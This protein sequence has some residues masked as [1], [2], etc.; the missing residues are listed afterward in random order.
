MS[1]ATV[2]RNGLRGRQWEVVMVAGI[3]GYQVL[4][5][6]TAHTRRELVITP[7][8][9]IIRVSDP[10][11]PVALPQDVPQEPVGRPQSDDDPPGAARMH[12]DWTTARRNHLVRRR[13]GRHI[14]G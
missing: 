13:I 12:A 14:G 8:G 2:T 1:D 5:V 6:Q 11:R 7:A 4:W 3:N 10:L 9:R